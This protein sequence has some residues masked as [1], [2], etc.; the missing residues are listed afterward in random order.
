MG[1]NLSTEEKSQKRR[2]SQ[3]KYVMGKKTSVASISSQS[4]KQHSIDLLN[5]NSSIQSSP[6]TKDLY[7]A[8]ANTTSKTIIPSKSA[9]SVKSPAV[10]EK[11]QAKSSSGDA[12]DHLD[13][14]S[15]LNSNNSSLI[16]ER[17]SGISKRNK[18]ARTT[19]YSTASTSHYRDTRYNSILSA[20]GFSNNNDAFQFSTIGDSAITDVSRISFNSFMD[21]KSGEDNDY[22]MSVPDYEYPSRTE[23]ESPSTDNVSTMDEILDLLKNHPRFT[24]DILTDIFASPRI[25]SNPDLQRE[26]FQAAEVW[27]LRPD[28]VSAKIC[29]ARCK[30]CGWGT[31]K[32]SR[33]GFKELQNLSL[34]NNW[35]AYYHLAQ[36]CYYGVEQA[37][38]SYTSSGG[39]APPTIIQPADPAL[40]CSWY[41]KVIE[42]PCTIYS[43]RIDYIIAQAKLLIAVINFTTDQITH[44][45]LEENINYVKDSA[46]AG[47]RKSEFL[48]ALLLRTKQT[49]DETSF[50]EYYTRSSN[51]GYTPSQIEL[52]LLLLREKSLEGVSWLNKA[53]TLGDPKAYH[54]LGKIYE[55]GIV[56]NADHTLAFNNYQI[57][58]NNFND[59]PSQ[60]RLGF[61]YL[62][63]TMGLEQDDAKA[64]S[65]L[66]NA[67]SH[68]HAESQYF[69]GIMYRDNKVPSRDS[70]QNKKEALSL[71]RSSA[72][73]S[74]HAAI[75]E[76]ATCFEKGIG[77]SVNH[78]I[79]TQYYEKAVSIPGKCLPSAQLTFA[80][81]LHKNGK[82][83]KSLKLYS[84]AAGL[85]PS[86][87]NTH[88]GSDSIVRTAKLM[89]ALFYLDEKDTTTP[90]VPQEAFDM[91]MNLSKES[92]NQSGEVHYWIAVCY[93]EGVPGVVKS[94]L[95]ESFKH[96]M[97][98]AK[99][100]YS[101]SQFQV[102]HMLCKGL[103]VSEDRQSAFEWLR[104]AADQN[105]A[106]ALYYVGI[107][108]YNG[109]GQIAKDIDQARDYF[110]RS[111]VL[112]NTESM[113]SYAQICYE[114]VKENAL[115]ASELER[116]LAESIRWY[117]KAANMNHP[118][119]LRELGRIYG[120]KNDL[121]TSAE[122]YK[123]ASKLNDAL[124]TVILGGYYENGHGVSM[125]KQTAISYYEKAIELGQPTALFAIAELY[126]KLKTYDK[127]YGYYKRVTQDSRIST[128]FKSSKTS[129]LKMALYSLNYDSNTLL[130]KATTTRSSAAAE[131]VRI[132]K[133]LKESNIKTMSPSEAF[134]ALSSLA[135]QKFHD[136][137]FWM[138]QCYQDGKGVSQ[139]TNALIHWLTKA[140]KEF[141]DINA[142]MELASIY[143]HGLYGVER[144]V[145]YAYQL[146]QILGERNIAVSQHRLGEYL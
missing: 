1:A 32:N 39:K 144:N 9:N 63:G 90:Y 42:T 87:L 44:D 100:G 117:K 108:Y 127:A 123:K 33:Q 49:T 135:T 85:E 65:Y 28:D 79:A 86:P 109:S 84:L 77:T 19:R 14:L 137:Y 67:A 24:Y 18:S 48:L 47:N 112:G 122:Y 133:I 53:A 54:H 22:I 8:T 37:S 17:H 146:Y 71:F 101:N 138:A 96:Y 61:H 59:H 29:V 102:G 26:A 68:Q 55:F 113:V 66:S 25:R 139:N 40:A 130:Y 141:N 110:K 46:I 13:K 94:N 3:S 64:F 80:T 5:N 60:F 69:L 106:N 36:C 145:P 45:N 81:F 4:I 143:E 107:Y 30:L 120:T 129:R 92:P 105:H 124:S 132:Q 91:L 31:P 119:S 118:T 74:I 38:E 93:E 131:P 58:A 50:K 115:P 97:I 103:G 95:S 121:K 140:S 6:I 34:K 11:R 98:S 116:L 16:I 125:N 104:A 136:A 15:N 126:D 111:A 70:V 57:A 62:N 99:L 52:G 43:D 23:T 51:K 78:A 12:L 88:A 20:S 82:Y 73:H 128:N 89:I 114:K 83:K 142:T 10:S 7:A 21:H 72:S 76:T 75:T 35:E 41:K 27:S 56:V 134:N 2:L